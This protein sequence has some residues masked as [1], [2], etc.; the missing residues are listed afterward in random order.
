[1]TEKD[2]E[3]QELRMKIEELENTIKLMESK[4]QMSRSYIKFL[5]EM[6]KSDSEARDLSDFEV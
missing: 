5:E 6:V 3:I 2:K 4:D 1:M